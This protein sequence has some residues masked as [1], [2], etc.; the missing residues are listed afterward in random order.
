MF[1]YVY[2]EGILNHS[3]SVS[4]LSKFNMLRWWMCFVGGTLMRMSYL[5]LDCTQMSHCRH[6]G[7]IMWLYCHRRYDI[8]LVM[9][10]LY[11]DI[12]QM[13]FTNYYKNT[14]LHLSVFIKIV[15]DS[16]LHGCWKQLFNKLHRYNAK[17]D[18][19]CCV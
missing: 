13:E 15:T 16:K 4:E 18:L 6:S 3:E 9:M 5:A 8:A 11:A 7:W 12:R 19:F 10:S 14:L 2:A 1:R 17:L